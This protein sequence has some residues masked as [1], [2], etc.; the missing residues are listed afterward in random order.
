M[1][2]IMDHIIANHEHSEMEK[3]SEKFGSMEFDREDDDA[4]MEAQEQ[5]NVTTEELEN[6][7]KDGGFTI[8]DL[9][10]PEAVVVRVMKEILPEKTPVAKDAR[11]FL[12]RTAVFFVLYL[13]DCAVGLAVRK[14]RKTILPE[15]VLMALDDGEFSAMVIEL[16]A[17]LAERKKNPLKAKEISVNVP[18]ASLASKT[19][20]EI[21]LNDLLEQ[22]EAENI[23]EGGNDPVHDVLDENNIDL[24]RGG[25]LVEPSGQKCLSE[26]FNASDDED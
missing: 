5:E 26:A 25:E 21:V 4:N 9:K 18:D 17:L 14:K 16:K 8:D 7:G 24:G 2:T 11:D 10:F 20:T 6:S 3:N 19:S 23:P 22:L 1:T 13:V 12:S 15:D